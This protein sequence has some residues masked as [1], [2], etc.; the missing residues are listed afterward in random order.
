MTTTWLSR[1]AGNGSVASKNGAVMRPE[2]ETPFS[3]RDSDF[4]V[5][6]VEEDGQ[7]G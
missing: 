4:E 1:T 2:S 7:G 6:I 3:I 5:I